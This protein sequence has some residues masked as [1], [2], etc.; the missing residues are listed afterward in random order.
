MADGVPFHAKNSYFY[1]GGV[2]LCN[3]NAWNITR[4]VDLA[5]ATQFCDTWKRQTIGLRSATGNITAMQHLDKRTLVDAFGTEKAVY[6]YFDKTD[7]TNYWYGNVIFQSQANDGSTFSN[8]GQT[9][10]WTSDDGNGITY[11]GFA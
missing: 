8:V 1:V 9:A 2:A 3:A 10:D 4:T 7:A 6:C 5:E 11:M